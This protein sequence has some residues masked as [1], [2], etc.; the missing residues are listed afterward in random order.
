MLINESV[1]DQQEESMGTTILTPFMH[2]MQMEAF[3]R[4][5]DNLNVLH[6]DC[7]VSNSFIHYSNQANFVRDFQEHHKG[8][9][10]N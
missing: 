7:Q 8:I 10:K 5:M 3:G 1:T 2:S 4:K 9:L 6:T